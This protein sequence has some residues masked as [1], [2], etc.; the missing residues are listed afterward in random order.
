M[1]VAS[2]QLQEA[3]PGLA[4]EPDALENTGETWGLEST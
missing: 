4:A 1:D 2:Q 3:G